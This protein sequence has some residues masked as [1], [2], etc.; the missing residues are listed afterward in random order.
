MMQHICVSFFSFNSDILLLRF[1]QASQAWMEWLMKKRKAFDQRGDM[2]VAAWAEQQQREMNIR[3]RRLSRS[4]VSN[5]TVCMMLLFY[6]IL[7]EN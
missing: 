7:F 2:A 6:H 1:S 5:Y 4:K 3:A